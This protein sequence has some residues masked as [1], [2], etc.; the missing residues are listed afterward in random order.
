[1][2]ARVAGDLSRCLALVVPGEA[3]PVRTQQGCSASWAARINSSQF[4]KILLTYTSVIPLLH[5]RGRERDLLSQY[6]WQSFPNYTC[7]PAWCHGNCCYPK[8]LQQFITL[9]MSQNLQPSHIYGIR[10]KGCYLILRV[11]HQYDISYSID[12]TDMKVKFQHKKKMHKCLR[13][14]GMLTP[15]LWTIKMAMSPRMSYFGALISVPRAILEKYRS[16]WYSPSLPCLS[17]SPETW[18]WWWMLNWRRCRIMNLTPM[19][20]T[21]P[22]W[23]ETEEQETEESRIYF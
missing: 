6:G 17:F 1:M 10:K 3:K 20:K 15:C 2:V 14:S 5:M 7:H 18:I 21:P 23:T 9:F 11:S 4:S 22:K 8:C 12:K 16:I 19:Y 13:L